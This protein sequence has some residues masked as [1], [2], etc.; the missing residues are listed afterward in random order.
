M[1]KSFAQRLQAI[2]KPDDVQ[3]QMSLVKSG[4]TQLRNQAKKAGT[5]DEKIQILTKI[6]QSEA[7]LFQLRR[8]VFDIEDALAAGTPLSEIA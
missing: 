6:R 7:V 8:S 3:K 1:S 5:L 2:R 4:I